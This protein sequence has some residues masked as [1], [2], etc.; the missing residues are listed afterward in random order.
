MVIDFLELAS[1]QKLLSSEVAL[2][3]FFI[4]STSLV[5]EAKK[6]MESVPTL[7]ESESEASCILLLVCLLKMLYVC[8]FFLLFC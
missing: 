8:I 1:I 6:E 3:V 2:K 5:A 7:R 4:L